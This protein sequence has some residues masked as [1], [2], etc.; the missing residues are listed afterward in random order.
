MIESTFTLQKDGNI[1]PV[2]STVFFPFDH[3]PNVSFSDHLVNY[4][5]DIESSLRSLNQNGSVL[6]INISSTKT[7]KFVK[8]LPGFFDGFPGNLSNTC[9]LILLLMD[10][11]N[12]E[13]GK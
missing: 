5:E 12:E 11:V 7:T 3:Q 1:F 13:K 10:L 9:A 4:I 2:K 6:F 8:F